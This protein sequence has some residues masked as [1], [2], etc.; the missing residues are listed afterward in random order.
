MTKQ[1]IEAE[2]RAM[3]EFDKT[4]FNHR[5]AA[6]VTQ[7]RVVRPHRDCGYFECVS[8]GGVE[9]SHH[10]PGSIQI[11]SRAAIQGED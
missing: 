9:G 5:H 6:G 7:Y 11:F 8:V 4:V 1:A 10:F 3:T 2:E